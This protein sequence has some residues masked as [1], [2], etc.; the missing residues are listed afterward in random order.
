M[1][2]TIRSIMDNLHDKEIN[3]EVLFRFFRGDSTS[4]EAKKIRDWIALGKDNEDRYNAVHDL[5]DAYLLSAPIKIIEKHDAPAA[6]DGK[7]K[8]LRAVTTAFSAIA[9][10]VALVLVTAN[11]VRDKIMDKVSGTY[12]TVKVPDGHRMDFTLAD[13]TTVQL[14]SGATLSY[15][16]LFS[17]KSR[18][19]RLSGEAY[20][21]VTH[22]EDCPFIVNTFAYNIE[23]LGTKFSV[24]A[25]EESGSFSAV[26]AEGSIK[27]AD[28]SDPSRSIVMQPDQK[29]S[30]ADGRIVLE[31]RPAELE[32]QWTKGIIDI[33][34][35]GFEKLVRRLEK[36]YGVN[37]IVQREEM[38]E[39]HCTSGK[40]RISDG[41]EHALSILSQ[42][43]DFT[44]VK[45]DKTGDIY[46]R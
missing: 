4:D 26:L 15:P 21:N 28:A 36:A 1:F 13:G 9:A 23:V 24:D 7:R 19:V 20:F 6:P 40:V 22:N 11:S 14:N 42:L 31:N 17:D 34:N 29:A 45:D 41:I 43:S 46:I 32:T 37:I 25:D 3:D 27:L 8:T 39:I 18:T 12:T 35:T 30:I 10:A 44:Y 2:E 5:Y 16:V 33:S 38:P